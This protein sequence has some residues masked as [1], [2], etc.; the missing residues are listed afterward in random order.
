MPRS[1]STLLCN[2]LS[3]NPAFSVGGTSGL[4]DMMLNVR[5]EWDKIPEFRAMD[6]V[7]GEQRKLKTLR[8]MIAGYHSIEHSFK[9]AFNKSRSW[10]AHLDMF[11]VA[12]AQ[13]AKV[14]VPVRD[15]RDILASFES[16]WRETAALRQIHYE[17]RNYYAFQSV[18]GRTTV[19][20]AADGPVGIAYNRIQ[21]AFLRGYGDR[22]HLVSYS[23]LCDHP[24][25]VL[26][27]IYDF[28]GE[29]YFAHDFNDIT[30]STVEDDFAYG[31]PGLHSV[32]RRLR[33]ARS[34]WREV[35]GEFADQYSGLN[36]F[37]EERLPK[38]KDLADDYFSTGLDR[39]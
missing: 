34:R 5:A 4:I 37:L 11:E 23:R 30:P 31:I 3:Q 18:V 2:I 6:Q 38:R 8:G 35:L 33:P 17:A 36:T 16:L 10:I 25:E 28:L 29:E 32:E 15:V 12:M 24:E 9:V 22:L 39:P 14:I 26:L 7:E 20:G 27:G 13:K 21:D 1:G 19:W